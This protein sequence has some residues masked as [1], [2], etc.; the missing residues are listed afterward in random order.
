MDDSTTHNPARKGAPGNG[1]SGTGPLHWLVG[2][3]AFVILVQGVAA[4]RNYIEPL[5][6]AV[7]LTLALA[8]LLAA[9]RQRGLPA[10][11]ALLVILLGLL[12]GG[13]AV[14]LLVT[15]TVHDFSQQLPH[16]GALL[17]ARLAQATARVD[18]LLP[19]VDLDTLTRQ[20]DPSLAMG[21][22]SALLGGLGQ[23]VT[24]GMLVLVIVLFALLEAGSL[25]G[26]LQRATRN[27]AT[28][29]RFDRIAASINRYLLIKG[30]LSALNGLAIALWFWFTGVDYAPMWGLL[31][32]L[33]NFVPGVGQPLALVP[34]LLLAWL[35]LPGETLLL[36]ALGA[37]VING[38][39]GNWLE[40]KYLG[41]GLGLSTLVVIL[42][43][44]VWGWALGPVGMLLSVPLTMV[45]KIVLEGMP[46]THAIAVLLGPADNSQP[47][48]S[49]APAATPRASTPRAAGPDAAAQAPRD[50]NAAAPRRRRRRRKTPSSTT[51]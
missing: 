50:S 13:A 46:E 20:L 27:A 37:F 17:D 18:H 28:L 29:A 51:P 2:L 12:A 39:V 6:L 26:K 25:R 11:L 47:A 45:V 9:L 44:V 16:Y 49:T 42:S 32:F 43:L 48:A 41:E 31:M 1:A 24:S 3:A 22:A 38:I 7:L 35:Q 36:V 5:L 34:P 14:T 33:L 19:A 15:H 21:F 4:A 23:L 40:P 30:L 10:P 8:P